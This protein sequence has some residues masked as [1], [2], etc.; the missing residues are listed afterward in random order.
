VAYHKDGA[1]VKKDDKVKI[2]ITEDDHFNIPT[3]NL[4]QIGEKPD[5]IIHRVHTKG[6]EVRT[7]SGIWFF[8]KEQLEVI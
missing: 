1:D 8:N 3:Y 7:C 6:C 2:S 5:G 4:I